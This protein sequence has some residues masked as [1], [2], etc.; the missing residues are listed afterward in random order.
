MSL[1]AQPSAEIAR[2]P[3]EPLLTVENL[4]R[5]FRVHRRTIARLV[6]RG[7]LPPPLK[8]GGSNRWKGEDIEEALG[9]F[10]R[11]AGSVT[12]APEDPIRQISED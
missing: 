7:E 1:V 5:L 2:A 9:Q 8:V 3:I 4:E 6:K 10:A 11:Q 12:S